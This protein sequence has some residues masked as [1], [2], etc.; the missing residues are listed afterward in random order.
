MTYQPIEN[1][2]IVGDMHTVALVG[3]DGSIA[4]A[5][6]CLLQIWVWQFQPTHR[7]GADLLQR[8]LR[9]LNDPIRPPKRCPPER[10]DQRRAAVL[11]QHVVGVFLWQLRHGHLG[12]S[13]SGR[14][15]KYSRSRRAPTH[16]FLSRAALG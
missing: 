7:R 1:Y 16:R 10:I 5:K 3:T 14:R 8:E 15:S 4:Q 6:Q 2:G 12:S 9:A 11:H 13:R